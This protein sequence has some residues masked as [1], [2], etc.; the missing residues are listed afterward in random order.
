MKKVLI[1]GGSGFLGSHI[2][3]NLSNSNYQVTIFD[4]FKSKWLKKNQKIIVSNMKNIKKLENEIKKA[5]VVYHLAAMSDIGDCMNAPL[6]SAEN[7]IL[8]TINILDLCIKHKVERLIFASTIYVHSSQGGFYRITKDASE[9]Y[10]EEYRKRFSLNYTILRY[11]T[12]YGLRSSKKNNLTK[13]IN[14]AIEQ[15]R[16][17]YSGGTSEAVRKYI[18]VEDAAKLSC[19]VLQKKFTN[20]HV[21][22]TGK[23]N[24]KISTIMS[25]LSK[26]LKI[27]SKPKYQKISE[28]GHY[29]KSP[30]NKKKFKE[31]KLFPKNS[32]DIK[33]GLIELIN[34]LN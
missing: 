12:I 16:L 26:L 2:A 33:V 7:N 17:E 22:I 13:I 29:D 14:T 8:F 28:Y 5:E 24:L 34:H 23:K 9:Q 1:I 32:K 3:D 15:G 4:K 21:L 27:K 10:I 25:I 19:V 31:L 20:K 6:K 18:N 11:G 30:Y